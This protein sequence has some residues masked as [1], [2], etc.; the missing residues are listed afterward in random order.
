MLK[1]I[2]SRIAKLPLFWKITLGT[3]VAAAVLLLLV[4]SLWQQFFADTIITWV[5]ENTIFYSHFSLPRYY[6][7]NSYDKLADSLLSSTGI[8]STTDDIIKRELAFVYFSN[9]DKYQSLIFLRADSPQK[10]E[11]ILREKKVGYRR[12][13]RETFVIGQPEIINSLISNP[14][15]QLIAK[16]KNTFSA[17]STLSIYGEKQFIAT[18]L[19]NDSA[20]YWQYVLL[21]LAGDGDIHFN[22]FSNREKNW[23]WFG[24]FKGRKKIKMVVPTDS[25]LTFNLSDSEKILTAISSAGAPADILEN[26]SDAKYSYGLDPADPAIK[27]LAKNKISGLIRTKSSTSTGWFW[28]DNEIILKIA[29]QPSDTRVK[30]LEKIFKNILARQKPQDRKVQLHDGSIITEQLLHPEIIKFSPAAGLMAS[31][32]ELPIRIF[33]QTSTAGLVFSTNKD[34]LLATT[35]WPDGHDFISIK[36]KLLGNRGFWKYLNSFDNLEFYDNG[37]VILK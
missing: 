30:D 15:N 34:L 22:L 3:I 24:E 9:G 32:P 18:L 10:L 1:K 16:T 17:W 28:A 36:I 8:G 13:N 6:S 19:K 23:G 20:D 4:W 21:T 25:D 33:Y 14:Q 7:N 2:T 26:L 35:T 29:G 27:D 31:N 11:K 37:Q 5:P 12:L